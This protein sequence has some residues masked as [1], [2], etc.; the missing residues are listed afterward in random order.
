MRPTLIDLIENAAQRVGS[1][2]ELARQLD[3]PRQRLNDWKSGYRPCPPKA[4][5]QIAELAGANAKDWVWEAVMGK[6]AAVALA[7]G[8][9]AMLNFGFSGSAS[10]AGARGEYTTM[11]RAVRR[12]L[13]FA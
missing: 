3:V 10:A 7:L 6:A 12:W 9:G 5:G 8:V 2:A 13:R 4:Q 1:H 11:Y